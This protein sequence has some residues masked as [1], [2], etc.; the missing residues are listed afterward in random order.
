MG[1]LTKEQ[2]TQ[3]VLEFREEEVEIPEIQPGGTLLIR[4]LSVRKR[5]SLVKGIVDN[6]GN[7][8][9]LEEMQAR[10]FSASVVDPKFTRDEAKALM[11]GWPAAVWDRVTAKVDELSPAPK[12][13]QRAVAHD[14]PDEPAE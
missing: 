9:D 1:R 2:V 14:F 8:T 11:G 4:Q 13:V 6:E 10:M 3:A 5:T 12:E 7:V